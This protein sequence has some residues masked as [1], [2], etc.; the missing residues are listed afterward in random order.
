MVQSAGFTLL[1]RLP[2]LQRCK[3]CLALHDNIKVKPQEHR[4]PGLGQLIVPSS[5][6]TCRERTDKVQELVGVIVAA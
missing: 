2:L 1:V 4:H 5:H 6:E 3:Q